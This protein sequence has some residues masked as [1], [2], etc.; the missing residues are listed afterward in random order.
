MSPVASDFVPFTLQSNSNIKDYLKANEK[1]RSEMQ[2]EHPNLFT[3]NGQGQDPHTLFIGCSDSRYNENVV[4]VL[5]G[6]VFTF[7]NIANKVNVEDLTCL[8]TLEFAIN[9]LKV[10]KII[11]CGHTDCGGIK[12]CLKDQRKELPGLQC[13]HLHQYLQEIDDLI[14]ENKVLLNSPEYQNDLEKQSRLLSIL[15]VKKQY[16]SLLSVDTVQKALE[17]KSIET[18][19]LLYNVDSGKVEMIDL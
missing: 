9:V 5:P 7:K 6:E 15:N 19:G 16:E 4:G 8:A 3:L 10:N 12:T 18:Y 11:I 13:S 2:N 1:W 14:H 17:N